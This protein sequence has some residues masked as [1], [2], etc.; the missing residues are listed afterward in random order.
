VSGATQHADALIRADFHAQDASG[1]F[2]NR[3]VKAML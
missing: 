3:A 1:T 2:S